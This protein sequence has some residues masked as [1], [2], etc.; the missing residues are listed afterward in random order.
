MQIGMVFFRGTKKIV[1]QYSNRIKVRYGKIGSS[2]SH[3]FA[4]KIS[5]SNC[6]T[7]FYSRYSPQ[8]IRFSCWQI[9]LIFFSSDS[10]NY[11]HSLSFWQIEIKLHSRKL[12]ISSYYIFHF[13]VYFWTIKCCLS[14][15]FF[16]FYVFFF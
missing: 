14:N 6:K 12:S 13:E 1:V 11:Y 9:L 16:M 10:S 2:L 7:L 4:M 15:F 3:I 8:T 5:T